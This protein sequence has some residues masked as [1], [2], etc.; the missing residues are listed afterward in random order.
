[1]LHKPPVV[2][3]QTS[4]LA[5]SESPEFTDFKGAGSPEFAEFQTG[6]TPEVSLIGQEDKYAALRGFTSVIDSTENTGDAFSSNKS[7]DITSFNNAKNDDITSFNSSNNDD[8]IHEKEDDWHNF[9]SVPNKDMSS[10]IAY[11]SEPEQANAAKVNN[12]ICPP[13]SESFADFS[14]VASDDWSD[15]SS[16]NFNEAIKI[17]NAPIEKAAAENLP[18]PQLFEDSQIPDNTRSNTNIVNIQKTHIDKDD[19]L[20]ILIKNV[21]MAISK[22][23]TFDGE[24]SNSDKKSFTVKQS[25]FDLM[26]DIDIDIDRVPPPMDF[27]PDDQDGEFTAFPYSGEHVE[28][29][30]ERPTLSAITTKY[31]K[32]MFGESGPVGF[33]AQSSFQ[34]VVTQ[35]KAAEQVKNDTH[36]QNLSGNMFDGENMASFK[37][38]SPGEK[39][40]EQKEDSQSVSSIPSIQDMDAG[41]DSRSISSSE[42]TAPMESKS[43]DSLDLYKQD[44]TQA[45]EDQE[46]QETGLQ[47]AASSDKGQHCK[48]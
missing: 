32:N 25:N 8:I 42:Y 45:T 28:D 44:A 21:P 20:G 46:D 15:F 18:A 31:S 1:M 3:G 14:A 22:D 19:I 16:V 39:R 4:Q 38:D 23:A 24:P 47:T 36:S 27:S 48:R 17:E 33:G 34:K 35:S 10:A 26:D 30:T 29:M 7:D 6:P 37:E 9:Q 2:L 40:E 43:V 41:G 5:T 11:Q 13:A 12:V